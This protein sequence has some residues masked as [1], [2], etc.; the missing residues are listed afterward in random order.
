MMTG[1]IKLWPTDLPK[2]ELGLR[3]MRL[4]TA[5][6]R[7][8]GHTAEGFTARELEIIEL[9]AQGFNSKQIGEMLFISKHT[10]DT[11]RKNINRKGNFNGITDIVLFAIVFGSTP[12][13]VEI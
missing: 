1:E 4:Q 9:L 2:T 13:V 11:H 5:L 6:N 7:K 10:V 8:Y 3:L 12:L